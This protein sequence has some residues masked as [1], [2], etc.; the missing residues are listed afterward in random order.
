MANKHESWQRFCQLHADELAPLQRVEIAFGN[1]DRF[2]D[3]LTRGSVETKAQVVRLEEL[4]AAEFAALR[5][6]VA[7]YQREWQTY[8]TA[9]EFAAWF[10]ELS[11]RESH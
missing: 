6:F 7:R 11:R 4:A 5:V 9:T 1:A 3:L 8:F 10:R 2:A